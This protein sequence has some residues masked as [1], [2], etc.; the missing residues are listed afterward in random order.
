[1]IVKAGP[2]GYKPVIEGVKLKNLTHGDKTHL[3]EVKLKKGAKI[4]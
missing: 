1:M 2:E 4:T 3:T